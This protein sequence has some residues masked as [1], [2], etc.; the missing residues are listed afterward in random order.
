MPR[1]G[2]CAYCGTV[3]LLTKDEI[4][5][6][7][8]FSRPLPMDILKIP[9]C[10]K[11]NNGASLDDEYFKTMLALKDKAGSHTEAEAIR[12]SVFRGLKLPRKQ[13]FTRSILRQIRTVKLHSPSGLYLG[14][15]LAYDVDLRRL[16]SV[17]ARITKGLFWHHKSYRLPD[18]FEV[19]VF[20]Q[21]GLAQLDRRT[22]SELRDQIVAPVL[23][24]PVLEIG[25]GV[26][27]YWYSFAEDREN[28]SAWI[29]EFYGDVRFV[30]I[31]LPAKPRKTAG[32][33]Q[34]IL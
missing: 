2:Q 13:N 30:A 21:D 29:L 5:P 15:H 7:C 9:S 10:R 19:V 22:L 16:D 11:C 3:A 26:M 6:R 27:R 4:P 20:C 23:R 14:K 32:A 1:I 34:R 28:A 8:L 24:Q 12:A 17:V 25:R 18:G 31:T 33:A